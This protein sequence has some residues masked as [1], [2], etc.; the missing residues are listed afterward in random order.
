[1]IARGAHTLTH[2]H[3][4]TLGDHLPT[5]ALS[6]SC[7]GP[8]DQARVFAAVSALES[9]A[10]LVAPFVYNQIFA[11]TVAVLPQA[12]FMAMASTGLIATI[13]FMFVFVRAPLPSPLES[14]S[15]SARLAG[16]RAA[17]LD[18]DGHPIDS[19]T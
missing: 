7:Y 4:T 10:S 17:S 5:T 2:T 8:A 18:V 3:I 16:H 14:T 11:E 12:V 6:S 9:V 13:L 19:V 1:M 15:S